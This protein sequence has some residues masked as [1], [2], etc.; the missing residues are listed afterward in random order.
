MKRILFVTSLCLLAMCSLTSCMR[1]VGYISAD[2]TMPIVNPAEE[3]EANKAVTRNFYNVVVNGRKLD[4]LGKFLAP[5]FVDH[6]AD[7]PPFGR[8][9]PEVKESYSEWF[10]FM[11]DAHIT[12]DSMT[13]EGDLISAVVTMSG[14]MT[15]SLDG[16]PPNHKFAKWTG[17]DVR[18]Y[19]DRM[20]TERWGAFNKLGMLQQLQIFPGPPTGE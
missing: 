2:S 11:S 13:A 9:I 17:V 6:N 3:A 7:L 15:D 1:K 12:V 19:K 4:S 20:C 14:T 18:R 16:A 10:H 8:G 5:T